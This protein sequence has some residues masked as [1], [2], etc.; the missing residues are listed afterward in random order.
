MK[1]SA[2]EIRAAWARYLGKVMVATLCVP[3]DDDR[4]EDD[5]GE[6]E[7]ENGILIES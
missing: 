6:E 1:Y 7:L 3:D 4:E 2:E 5:E